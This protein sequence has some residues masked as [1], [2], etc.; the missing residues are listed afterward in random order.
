[1]MPL[2]KLEKTGAG[3]EDIGALLIRAQ[4]KT[5]ARIIAKEYDGEE[6]EDPKKTTITTIRSVGK[7]EVILVV[8]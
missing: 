2:F 4:S 7:S 6:W 5:G 1:M 8:Y 3:P